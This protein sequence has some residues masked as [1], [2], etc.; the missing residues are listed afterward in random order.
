VLLEE[1]EN[2]L[3]PARVRDAV[4]VLRDAS[5]RMQIVMATHSPLVINE[6]EGHEVTVLHRDERDIIRATRLDGSFDYEARSRVY[7]NGELWLAHADGEREHDLFARP[8]RP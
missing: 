6:L 1:P 5:A 8:R 4:R 2:G 3:H 7:S